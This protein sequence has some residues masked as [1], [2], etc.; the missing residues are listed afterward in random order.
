MSRF[1]VILAAFV[2]LFPTTAQ[3]ATDAHLSGPFR[4]VSEQSGDAREYI[5][6]ALCPKPQPCEKVALR[7]EGPYGSHFNSTLHR[8][9]AGV[10][11][12][13]E[14]SGTVKECSGG[15]E[16]KQKVRH[17]ITIQRAE[18]GR[19]T[20]IRGRSR[21]KMYGCVEEKTTVRFYGERR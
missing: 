15:G 14:R 13:R 9:S 8:R 7:R 19:A 3:A 16:A 4:I 1:H 18:N 12:G 21:Y 6:R 10:Y 17:T 20:V 2:L 11:K 5:F